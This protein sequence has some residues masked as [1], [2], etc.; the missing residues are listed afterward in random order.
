MIVVVFGGGDR[1]IAKSYLLCHYLWFTGSMPGCG[2]S[3]KD[4]EQER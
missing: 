2:S 1:A 4:S 3:G